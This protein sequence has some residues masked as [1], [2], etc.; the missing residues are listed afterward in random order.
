MN[1]SYIKI[2]NQVVDEFFNELIEIFPEETKIK[3]KY[4]L[5]QA[6]IKI[7]IKKPCIV[8]MTVINEYLEQIAMRDEQFFLGNNKPK[9]L[10]EIDLWKSD[11]SPETKLAVWKY[12]Q[13][14]ITIGSNVIEM[15]VEK[16]NL[17]SYIINFS[18]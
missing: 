2:F 6:I 7:N 13:S 1:T 16:H 9:I 11:L 5:F 4:I 14:L 8:F 3:T 12:I 15:P 17:I 10:E 18:N